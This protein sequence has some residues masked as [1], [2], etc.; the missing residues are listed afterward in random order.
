M[1]DAER[2][3]WLQEQAKKSYTGISFDYVPSVDGEP[4]G[5]RFMR[6]GYIGEP[7]KTLVA[8]IDKEM[9]K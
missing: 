2:L 5:Y 8:A 4:S 7:A 9:K 1:N 3:A 6:R